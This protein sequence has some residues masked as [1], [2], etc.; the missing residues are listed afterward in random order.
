VRGTVVEGKT[1]SLNF[2]V[3]IPSPNPL[4]I[5]EGFLVENFTNFAAD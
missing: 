3:R 5:G 1:R 4:P 2:E